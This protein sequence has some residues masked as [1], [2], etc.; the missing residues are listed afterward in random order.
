MKSYK[1]CLIREFEK[2]RFNG[3]PLVTDNQRLLDVVTPPA[4]TSIKTSPDRIAVE[5]FESYIVEH[6]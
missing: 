2:A 5:D 1:I 4:S 6:E 3:Q